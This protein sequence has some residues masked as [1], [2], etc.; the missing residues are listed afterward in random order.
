MFESFSQDFFNE[1][2]TMR[3]RLKQKH[4][5]RWDAGVSGNIPDF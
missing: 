5:L 3:R 2:G 4:R 1:D